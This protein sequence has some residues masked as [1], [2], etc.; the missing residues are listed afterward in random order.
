MKWLI[1]DSGVRRAFVESVRGAVR[2]TASSG[3]ES[4]PGGH[5]G[6]D[7]DSGSIP[8]SGASGGGD[9]NGGTGGRTGTLARQKLRSQNRH[10]VSGLTENF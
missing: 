4:G 2:I 7:R 9:N 3:N 5:S 1:G 6:A 10:D 8:E